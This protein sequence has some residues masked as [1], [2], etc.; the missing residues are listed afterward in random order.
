[1]EFPIVMFACRPSVMQCAHCLGSCSHANAL[2]WYDNISH[3]FPYDPEL[4]PYVQEIHQMCKY[5]LPTSRQKLSS[6]RRT[7][8]CT[9]RQGHQNYIPCRF[10]GGQL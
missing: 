7:K 2:G 1:M 9:D 10:T 8:K 3:F 4:D 6:D 5:E